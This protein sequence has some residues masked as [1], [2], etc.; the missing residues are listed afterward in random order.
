MRVF[1]FCFLTWIHFEYCVSYS[2]GH[3]QICFLDQKNPL[4]RFLNFPKFEYCFLYSV[5]YIPIL[6]VLTTFQVYIAQREF[7]DA[8]DLVLKASTWVAENCH[9]STDSAR[10]REATLDLEMRTQNL[11][12]VLA[13]ELS[14]QKSFQGGPRTARNAVKLLCRLGRSS[15]AA[16]LFL[17]HRDAILQ[18]SLKYVK[19]HIF[20]EG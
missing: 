11:I 20:W 3:L 6:S 14:T 10:V 19:V 17:K 7:G 8:V 2:L 16:D 13:S 15:Q 5:S 4:L 1:F 12:Q 9:K 18:A